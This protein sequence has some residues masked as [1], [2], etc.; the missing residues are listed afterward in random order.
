MFQT[1][2][3]ESYSELKTVY[4]DSRGALVRPIYRRK[5]DAS[6][7]NIWGSFK[8]P[9]ISMKL[10][11]KNIFDTK[12]GSRSGL[13]KISK[14]LGFAVGLYDRCGDGW[15]LITSVCHLYNLTM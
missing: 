4:S 2:S 7:K 11:P 8:F 6:T 12:V 3:L 10:L 1:W 14:M 15:A 5:G 9:D 13:S